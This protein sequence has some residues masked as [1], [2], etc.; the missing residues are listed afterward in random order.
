MNT[1]AACVATPLAKA[2]GWTLFHFLWEGAAIAAVLA[3]MLYGI[4][5]AA[6]RVRY[7][8][9]CA[10]LGAMA[11]AFAVTLAVSM[12]SQPAHSVKLPPI[13]QLRDWAVAP[14]DSSAPPPVALADRLA[15]ASPFWLAG[16]VGV[17]LYR[18]AGWT[19]AQRLRRVGT[20]A[21][22][23]RW[24][25]R[26]EALARDARIARP[27]VLLESCLVEIPAAVGWLR[28]A[29]LT[30]LGMLA[31][32]PPEQVEAILLHELAHIRRADYAVNLLQ[33]AIEGLLFYHPALWWV[34]GLVRAEREHCCDDWAAGRLGSAHQYATAL[35]AFESSRWQAPRAAMAADG[36]NLARR[37]RRLLV[38]P[39][40]HDLA[41]PVAPS[42]LL[43]ALAGVALAAWPQPQ[44]EPDRKPVPA[45]QLVGPAPDQVPPAP[46]APPRAQ[47]Q[48]APAPKDRDVRLASVY[49]KWLNEDVAYIITPEERAAFAKLE[50]DAEREKFVEQFWERRNPEPGVIENAFKEEHYR[51]IAYANEHFAAPDGRTPGWRTAR[52]RFYITDGPPDQIED[53]THDPEPFQM[54][55]YRYIERV[56]GQMGVRFDIGKDGFMLSVPKPPTRVFYGEP[57]GEPLPGGHVSVRAY[58]SGGEEISIPL[59]FLAGPLRVE[60]IVRP[61]NGRVVQSFVV[62]CDP[63]DTPVVSKS[64]V[65]PPGSYV[66]TVAVIANGK[67]YGEKLTFEVK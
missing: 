24:R 12:P 3:V 2:L 58:P 19:A 47:A 44:Q 30:P 29:I 55:K 17:F 33:S 45:A 65:L 10:A 37:I 64:Y 48:P 52:G 27:V 46:A 39:E 53:H 41:V 35:A 4:R 50:G 15:W 6:A 5:P 21:A 49:S 56:K 36:S 38:K 43:V 25:L 7:G 18:S 54:W 11:L 20:V 63:H 23:E 32:L 13:E 59:N 61:A 22:P 34:S 28:P 14:V 16:V 26:L 60:G 1:L 66:L 62:T 31:G 67:T 57:D 42:L 51:R 40:A 8:L 9:A